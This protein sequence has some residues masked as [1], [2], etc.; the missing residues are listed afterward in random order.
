L[1]SMRCRADLIGAAIEVRVNPGGGMSIVVTG[2]M[3][4]KDEHIAKRK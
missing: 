2:P 4:H 1:R 3:K